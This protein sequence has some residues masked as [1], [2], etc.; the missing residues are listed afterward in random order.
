MTA[1][2]AALWISSGISLFSAVHFGIAGL[3]RR[4]DSV[5]LVFAL[6]CLLIAIYMPLSVQWYSADS[7]ARVAQVARWEMGL[8]CVII[9]VFAWF[10]GLY[11]G[12]TPRWWLWLV[13]ACFGV[14]WVV[15]LNAPNSFLYRSILSIETMPLPWGGTA[16]HYRVQV[17]PLAYAYYALTYAIFFWALWCLVQIWKRGQRSKA[18]PLLIYFCLQFAATIVGELV[19]NTGLHSIYPGEF[20]FLVLV[21]LMSLS[22]G[23]E[24]RRRSLA[25][26]KSVALLCRET[27]KRQQTQDQLAHMAY[28][29]YLTGLPNRRYL[30][31]ILHER[32]QTDHS[33]SLDALLLLGLDYFKTINDSL[34]HDVG[35]DVLKQVAAK[36]QELLPEDAFLARMGG[37]EFAI[38]LQGLA[39]DPEQAE[40]QVRDIS[41]D[42]LT[43]LQSP[44]ALAGL[45]LV[46]GASI[47]ATLI[48]AHQ[49]RE[50]ELLRM[51]DTALHEAKAGNRGSVQLFAR[52]MKRQ[53]DER[54]EIERGLRTLLERGELQL[55]YQPQL[56]AKGQLFGAESLARWY[57]EGRGWISPDYFIPIAEETGLIHA[58]G[59]FVLAQACRQ[60]RGWQLDLDYPG[61]IAINVSPW[62]FSRP[63]FV[64]K[65]TRSVE[66]SGIDPCRVVL[67]LTESTLAYD[68]VA[69]ETKMR[70]LNEM[71]IRFSIDDFGTGYSALAS[72]K[73]LPLHELKVDRSFVQDMSLGPPDKLVDTIIGIAHHMGFAV[74]AEGVE[75]Q[76]QYEA[77]KQLHCDAYQGYLLGRPMPE[78]Q[79]AS[80]LAGRNGAAKR[81]LH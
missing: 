49:R 44:V 77:L 13:A 69:I 66:A 4:R 17:A 38:V 36:L 40:Q 63:D 34:S 23:Q 80:W 14:L 3:L 6:L 68:I 76:A 51:A 1:L 2:I 30:T 54:L 52:S 10:V 5:F 42:L 61:H 60:A 73:K 31:R 39:G 57:L 70:A 62:Q 78:T 28:H 55:Y 26:E 16:H 45:E 48:N 58:I 9:P 79:F 8:L 43:A 37:D 50:N 64:E 75:T 41:N 59:D 46:V 25:L 81:D 72:L 35:D 27:Q 67:E 20:V 65:V 53:A 47:G 12:H 74:V 71:G 21:V 18:V 19:D 24:L 32:A 33:Q 56:D 7:I 29:D 11:T 15:N 22:L